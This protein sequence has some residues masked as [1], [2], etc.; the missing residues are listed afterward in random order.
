MK[1]AISIGVIFT[2]MF[3]FCILNLVSYSKKDFKNFNKS[4]IFQKNHENFTKFSKLNVTIAVNN[5]VNKT[6]E[7]IAKHREERQ[8]KQK[9]RKC[10][11][12]LQKNS[13]MEKKNF[14]N[15]R[16]GVVLKA[17]SCQFVDFDA[18]RINGKGCQDGT[19]MVLKNK[20]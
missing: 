3:L 14:K 6:N 11:R 4:S 1:T 20:Y 5:K 7:L 16:K 15:E 19:K 9:K 17:G 10:V 2:L 12:K 18:V 13:N 8:R